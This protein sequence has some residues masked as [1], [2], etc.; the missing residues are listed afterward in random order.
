MSGA[1]KRHILRNTDVTRV[2]TGVRRVSTAICGRESPPL[3]PFVPLDELLDDEGRLDQ[4]GLC[5][6]CA[7]LYLLPESPHE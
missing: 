6:M 2:L 1:R 4:A 5:E 7:A 3:G